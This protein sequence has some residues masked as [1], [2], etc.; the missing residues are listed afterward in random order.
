MLQSEI[1]SPLGLQRRP[2]GAHSTLNLSVVEIEA[3]K[4]DSH[5]DETYHP[6]SLTKINANPISIIKDIKLLHSNL[7]TS[8]H[9]ERLNST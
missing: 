3:A 5:D 4:I 2:A 9:S 8:R 1:R 7:N 6:K